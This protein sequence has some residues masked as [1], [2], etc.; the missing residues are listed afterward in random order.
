MDKKQNLTGCFTNRLY[1]KHGYPIRV[2]V[3]GE[4]KKIKRRERM[5]FIGFFA[6]WVGKSC[7]HNPNAKGEGSEGGILMV[8]EGA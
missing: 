5:T 6:H 7:L 3:E 4:D 2:T 1:M 8:S